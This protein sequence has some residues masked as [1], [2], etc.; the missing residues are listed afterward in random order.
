MDPGVHLDGD[1]A[2]SLLVLVSGIVM[3]IC[4]APGARRFSAWLGGIGV[5]AGMVSLIATVM[6]PDSAVQFGMVC[7]VVGAAVILAGAFLDA[8]S[9]SQNQPVGAGAAAPAAS[10]DEAPADLVDVVQ[11]G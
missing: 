9:L 11:E 1:E 6:E 4:A 2:G 3:A 5:F 8:E 10:A 7:I